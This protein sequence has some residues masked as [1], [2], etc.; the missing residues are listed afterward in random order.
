MVR[1]FY[2]VGSIPLRAGPEE[3]SAGKL[4]WVLNKDVAMSS[5]RERVTEALVVDRD[6]EVHTG[7][8]VFRGTR[9]PVNT[10]TGILRAGGTLDEFLEG[11]PAVER[12]KAEAFLD[13]GYSFRPTTSRCCGMA[14]L[15]RLPCEGRNRS[16]QEIS[17]RRP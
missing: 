14:P 10:L 5:A 11:Y 16:G 12:W 3:R 2:G 8:L 4:V 9:V 6:P 15:K 13:K 17:T 7:D 1:I